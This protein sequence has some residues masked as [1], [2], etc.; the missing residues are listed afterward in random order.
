MRVAVHSNQL[1]LRGTEIALWDYAD[2]L[3]RRGHEITVFAMADSPNSDPAAVARFQERFDT[4]LY[5]SWGD[6][7]AF[8]GQDFVYMIKAG[9]RDA[10]IPAPGVRYGVHVVFP[11]R[12]PHGDVYA[13]ISRWLARCMGRGAF[14][15]VPH[16][17]E[18]ADHDGDMRDR[19][20]I[21]DSAVVFGR[22]GGYDTFDVPGV[23]D[24]I[25]AA[26]SQRDDIWFAFMNTQPGIEHERVVFAPGTADPMEKVAFI[27]SCD[28]MLHA[29]MQGETFGLAPAEFSLR[30]K[31]ILT[32]SGSREQAHIEMLGDKAFLYG[33]PRE[34]TALLAGFEPQPGH[35]WNA[36]RDYNKDA[37]SEV[38]EKVFLNG[39]PTPAEFATP[40][41]GSERAADCDGLYWAIKRTF[42]P[43]HPLR[44]AAVRARRALA[45]GSG[46]SA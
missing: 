7:K 12:D 46:D 19:L 4:R 40:P 24:A 31:P 3:E 42:P 21:P 23:W 1:S 6:V 10:L 9:G 2:G 35:D 16:I 37:V 39:E 14:P 8:A 33:S 34:L 44:Q 38:F 13:Y 30:N 17:V 45:R 32:W 36:Y 27:N 26:L 28:A 29:R 5:R 41:P 18:V 43:E 22:Y 25:G 11:V 20:G 15:W